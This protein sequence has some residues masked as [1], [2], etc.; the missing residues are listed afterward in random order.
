MAVFLQ[1][2]VDNNGTLL[3]INLAPRGKTHLK[4]PYCGETLIARKG[5]QLAHHFAHDGETCNAVVGQ[6]AEALALPYYDT[7]NIGLSPTDLEHLHHFHQHRTGGNARG[8]WRYYATDLDRL[9]RAG[10]IK[11]NPFV[12]Y[13]GSYELTPLGKIPFGEATLTAFVDFQQQKTIARH[14]DLTDALERAHTGLNLFGRKIDVDSE[15][16]AAHRVNLQLFRFQW[17]RVLATLLYFLEVEHDGGL[18]Y[19]V[20]VTTRDI[21]ERIGEIQRDLRPHLGEVIV[22][23]LRVLHHFGQV[24]RYFKHRYRAHAHP[25]GTFTEYFT[26]DNKRAVLTDLSKM[27]SAAGEKATAPKGAKAYRKHLTEV[28]RGVLSGDRPGI[29]EIITLARHCGDHHSGPAL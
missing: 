14:K 24:E 12:G 28:E 21:H 25:I 3:P 11:F 29:V 23:P 20:G 27:G 8:Y 7:F 26:F 2:G 4:C 5:K 13:S 17:Q 15:T 1:Y 19:K 18:L 6:D 16:I 9:E 10:A 22:K